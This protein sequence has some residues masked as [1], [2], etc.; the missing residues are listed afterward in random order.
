MDSLGP[1]F[2]VVDKMNDYTPDGNPTRYLILKWMLGYLKTHDATDEWKESYIEFVENI[3]ETFLDAENVEPS[4]QSVEFRN[5]LNE[6]AT[7][8]KYLYH[9]I[10]SKYTFDAKVFEIVGHNF[11]KIC[12][13]S[14]KD[15]ELN[16]LF[17][18][19]DCSDDMG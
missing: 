2:L 7:L 3:V 13:I 15:K 18:K 10:H 14:V 9:Q 8:S 16:S 6:T 11:L 1:V 17:E 12:D 5:L 19:M 4:N